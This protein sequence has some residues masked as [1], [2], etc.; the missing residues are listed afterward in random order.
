LGFV[1]NSVSIYVFEIKNLL[2]AGKPNTVDDG[3]YIA[4]VIFFK[5]I[6]SIG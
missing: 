3:S 5:D 4:N 6:D 1:N 2:I